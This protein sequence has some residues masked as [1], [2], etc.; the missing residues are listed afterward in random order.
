MPIQFK[1]K[2]LVGVYLL[3]ALGV[4]VYVPVNAVDIFDNVAGPWNDY[5]QPAKTPS[6]IPEST[7]MAGRNVVTRAT[8]TNAFVWSLGTDGTGGQ[9]RI[10][11]KRFAG[12]QAALAGFAVAFWGGHRVRSRIAITLRVVGRVVWLLPLALYAVAAI[13]RLLYVPCVWTRHYGTLAAGRTVPYAATLALWQIDIEDVRY[14]LVAFEE[15]VLLALVI[16]LY[17]TIFA[18]FPGIRRRV[19]GLHRDARGI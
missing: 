19:D 18:V 10:D 1:P 9:R 4:A 7:A 8:K 11:W 16:A 3:L 14:G 5:A 17:G 6:A 12:R 2:I 15:F 13:W